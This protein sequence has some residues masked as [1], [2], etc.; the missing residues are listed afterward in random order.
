MI[1]VENGMGESVTGNSLK[2][3]VIFTDKSIP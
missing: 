2:K 3:N 1:G